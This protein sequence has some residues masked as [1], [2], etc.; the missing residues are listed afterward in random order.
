MFKIIFAI[1]CMLHAS[2]LFAIDTLILGNPKQ[3]GDT[4]I[5]AN[6]GGVLKKVIIVEGA[7][8]DVKILAGQKVKA[9]DFTNS[10]DDAAPGFPQGIDAS[11]QNGTFD[12][13]KA[14]T[15][16]DEAGTGAPTLS[17]GATIENG[18]EIRMGTTSCY[19]TYFKYQYYSDNPGQQNVFVTSGTGGGKWTITG[20]DSTADMQY[21]GE[22]VWGCANNTCNFD[23]NELIDPGTNAIINCTDVANPTS[24][25]CYITPDASGANGW[26]FKVEVYSANDAN[27]FI[28]WL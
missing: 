23:V 8:G 16:T 18:K 21:Y 12:S 6:D 22:I 17:E 10:A 4:A 7:T 14:D 5:Q 15:I 1:I 20:C 26:C 28:T 24:A 13:L 19:R 9:D 3:D 11:G 2:Q 27:C 25:V